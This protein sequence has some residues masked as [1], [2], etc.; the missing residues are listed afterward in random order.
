MER[1]HRD[2]SRVSYRMRGE[3]INHAMGSRY[4]LP[5]NFFFKKSD[6]V[7]LKTKFSSPL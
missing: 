3:K 2:G 4:M 7:E 1:N 5:K 6:L